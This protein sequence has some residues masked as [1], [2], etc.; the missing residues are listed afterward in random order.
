MPVALAEAVR[1]L[2]VLALED[3]ASFR[4]DPDVNEDWILR[5]WGPLPV[6]WAGNLSLHCYAAALGVEAGE[7]A[8]VASGRWAAVFR[9]RAEKEASPAGQDFLLMAGRRPRVAMAG[10]DVVLDTVRVVPPAGASAARVLVGGPDRLGLLA[11]LLGR[12]AFFGLHPTR[13]SVRT[14][15]GRAEDR[16]ELAG[17]DGELT[18]AAALGGLEQ[19]LRAHIP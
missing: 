12:F 16:F 5:L 4:I 8:Q 18:A 7:A 13:L 1:Q 11:W 6:G 9:L 10:A 19:T 15:A 17:P 2:E 3:A 14:T